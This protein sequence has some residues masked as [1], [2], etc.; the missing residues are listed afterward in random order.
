MEIVV[1]LLWIVGWDFI[2]AFASIVCV[3]IGSSF[4]LP[5]SWR[6]HKPQNGF[7][8]WFSE[9]SVQ[10]IHQ[11]VDEMYCNDCNGILYQAQSHAS[12]KA[13]VASSTYL[14]RVS[15][16]STESTCQL[17][18]PNFYISMPVEFP[19]VCL[20]GSKD[21]ELTQKRCLKVGIDEIWWNIY[22]EIMKILFSILGPWP[23]LI[24]GSRSDKAK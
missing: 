10:F 7:N 6:R 20:P 5:C 1:E 22:D 19:Y 3:T 4:K 9:F 12:M 16:K 15:S 2:A 24:C 21:Q 17:Q 23:C 8:W 11:S 14:P 13:R 18:N